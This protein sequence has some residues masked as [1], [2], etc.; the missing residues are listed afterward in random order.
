LSRSHYVVLNTGLTIEDREYR[1]HY[2][3]PRLGDFAVLKVKD[4]ACAG[5]FDELWQL[6]K[7][8]K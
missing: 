2:G 3:M 5:L 8:A 4:G 1:G 7:A 6:P